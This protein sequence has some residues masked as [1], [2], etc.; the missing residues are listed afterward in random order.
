MKQN[1]Y[2][3]PAF[4]EGYRDL[5]EREAGL[6]AR[7]EEPAVRS[8]LPDLAGLSVLDLGSGFG[9][10]CRCAA[11][12]GA[13]KVVGVD[14]S[15]KM[16]AEAK[17]RGH[18]GG[19]EFIRAAIEDHRIGAGAY[20]LVVSRLAL[21]YVKDY[22]RVVR[23]VFRGLRPAGRF[24]LS[25]EHPLC[26]ALCRGWHTDAEGKHLFWPVDRYAREGK[27]RQH[28]FVEGVI[29]YHR[30]V[31]T[32]VNTLLEE[33][34]RLKRLLEPQAAPAPRRNRPDLREAARRPPLLV[35]AADRPA[36]ARD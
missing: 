34:F 32:Y 17:K 31:E 15:A 11:R 6:N 9:D 2:D 4:F 19:I 22:R 36:G 16:I 30:T 13:V 33:G 10:F 21:H 7:I 12:Q 26:T 27:R 1:I 29:K 8:V 5:R 28:W 3:D 18:G 14:I 23:S 35:I 24:V 20:D 25:V